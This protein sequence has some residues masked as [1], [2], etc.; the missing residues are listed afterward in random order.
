[1]IDDIVVVNQDLFLNA[2]SVSKV[3]TTSVVGRSLLVIFN[4]WG[5]SQLILNGTKVM[6]MEDI[7][8]IPR[9]IL[10]PSNGSF[11]ILQYSRAGSSIVVR[12]CYGVQHILS[13][14]IMD[15]KAE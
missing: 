11:P 7:Y 12:L 10:L 6:M 4:D 9:Y 1:M 15:A 3:I 14:R 8:I 5:L 2:R 13:S